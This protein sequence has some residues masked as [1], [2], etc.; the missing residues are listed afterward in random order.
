M[1]LLYYIYF[2][3]SYLKMQT[4]KMLNRLKSKK[5]RE[6]T[7]EVGEQDDGGGGGGGDLKAAS[8]RERRMTKRS[9][10]NVAHSRNKILALVPSRCDRERAPAGSSRSLLASLTRRRPSGDDW[11]RSIR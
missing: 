10:N 11:W 6:E 3:R 1:A 7:G 2:T 9:D 5:E 4:C 8:P